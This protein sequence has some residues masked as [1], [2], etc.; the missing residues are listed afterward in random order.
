MSA[1]RQTI[2][3]FLSQRMCVEDVSQAT[4]TCAQHEKKGASVSRVQ[5]VLSSVFKKSVRRLG[6]DQHFSRQMN[7]DRTL[8]EYRIKTLR[9]NLF[10]CKMTI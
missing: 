2:H 10:V 7:A 6:Q 4:V 3:M 1:R 9:H 5:G 8:S